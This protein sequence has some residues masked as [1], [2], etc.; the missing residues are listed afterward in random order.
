MAARLFDL[1]KEFIELD[2]SPALVHLKA[3]NKKNIL[4]AKQAERLMEY[5][6]DGNEKI[7][8]EYLGREDGIL[9]YDKPRDEKDDYPGLSMQAILD[10]S[11]ELALLL[12]NKTISE[13]V[14][15]SLIN[16]AKRSSRLRSIFSRFSKLRQL[17]K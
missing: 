14:S 13:K 3:N 17:F 10:I 9:F 8:R 1:H 4:T 15:D 12:K 16:T 7:A 2:R 11:R 5:C 6:K